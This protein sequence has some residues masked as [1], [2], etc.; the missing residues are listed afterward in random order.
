MQYPYINYIRALLIRGYRSEAIA[1]RLRAFRFAP[2]EDLEIDQMGDELF[3]HFSIEQLQNINPGPNYNLNKF[4]EESESVLNKLG[5]PEIIPRLKG[6]KVPAWDE[7]ILIM[8]DADIRVIVMCMSVQGSSPDEILKTIDERTG[9]GLSIEGL[10]YFFKY[11]WNIA[12]MSKLE[13]FHFLSTGITSKHKSLIL[14]AFH[15]RDG[16]VKWKIG[17]QNAA[18]FENI[19]TTIMNEAFIK[20]Q[21]E[22]DSDNVDNI[23]RVQQWANL[24]MRA[25][26]KLKENSTDSSDDILATLELKLKH[27]GQ[28]D[29]KTAEEQD[30]KIV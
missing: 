29:I 1:D 2:P 30:L 8:S 5:I 4:L 26:E 19:L 17:R 12:N 18:S 23:N 11:F 15:K 25:A 24:A 21:S 3:S 13:L 10:L 14:K 9:L 27:T 28:D 20:F 6:Q 22:V 16:E 7:A